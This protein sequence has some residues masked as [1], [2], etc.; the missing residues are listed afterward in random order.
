[1]KNNSFKIV[2]IHDGLI[3]NVDP[4]LISLKDTF[5]DDSVIHFENSNKGL[6]YVL[7]NLSQKM[8]VILDINFSQ[9]ELSGV[10]VFEGIKEKTALVYIIMVTARMLSEINHN[11]LITMINH[12]AFALE[13]VSKYPEILTLVKL[14]VHKMEARVDSA[15]EQF[16]NSHTDS[17]K[18][19]P[20]ITSREG[21]TYTLTDILREIR[22]Q[23]PFGQDMEKKI[24]LLAI[25]ML[26]RK[27]KNLDN[28]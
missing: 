17:E 24:L 11:D 28:D 20:Y 26:V 19:K 23:T 13:N 27:K 6:A 22:L 15:L 18:S 12:D 2:I 7:E 3:P 4:L 14:A 8:I 9:G 25:D 21:Q 16:I 10:Q 5:G 1:M